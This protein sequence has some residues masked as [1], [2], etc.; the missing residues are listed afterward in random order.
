M[1]STFGNAQLPGQFVGFGASAPSAGNTLNFDGGTSLFDTTASNQFGVPNYSTAPTTNQFGTANTYSVASALPKSPLPSYS[2]PSGLSGQLAQ[3]QMLANQTGYGG[4]VNDVLSGKE[5]DAAGALGFDVKA[6]GADSET[7][8]GMGN[9]GWGNVLGA[10]GLAINLMA[11]MD[12][13]E[14]SKQEIAASK[15]NVDLMK[16]DY[17]ATA[18]YRKSYMG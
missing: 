13:R 15:A 10:G 4:G 16:K 1:S 3:N 6:P 17:E 14:K 8:L 18:A 11:A 5:F 2:A 7:F 9:E 12:N